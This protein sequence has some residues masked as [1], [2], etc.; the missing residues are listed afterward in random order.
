MCQLFSYILFKQ[1]SFK[2]VRYDFT[3]GNT[4]AS[5]LSTDLWLTTVDRFLLHISFICAKQLSQV[6][7]YPSLQYQKEVS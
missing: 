6:R 3:K 5:S 7:V 1:F 2:L 4:F